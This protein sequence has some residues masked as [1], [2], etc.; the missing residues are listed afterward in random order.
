MQSETGLC[1]RWR[2]LIHVNVMQQTIH[3]CTQPAC[4][5][6][7]GGHGKYTCYANLPRIGTF[8]YTYVNIQFQPTAELFSSF[9]VGFGSNTTPQ[10][11]SDN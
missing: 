9:Q 7:A 8:G 4:F 11:Q 1:D 10:R 3:G 6:S 5:S 2:S